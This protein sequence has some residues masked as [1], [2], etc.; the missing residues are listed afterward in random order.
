MILPFNTFTIHSL[1][2]FMVTIPLAVMFYI[3][4]LK[5]GRRKLD[6]LSANFIFC[7]AAMCLYYF[8]VD[9]LIPAG[10]SALGWADGPTADALRSATLQLYRFGWA[11]AI[12]ILPVQLHFVLYYCRRNN[13]LRRYI[14]VGYIVALVLVPTIWFTSLWATIAS[15]P[16]AETSSWAVTIPWLPATG[17]APYVYF[18]VTI[19]IQIYGL[20]LLWRTRRQTVTEF[21]DSLGGR[22]IVFAAFVVQVG[23]GLLDVVNGAVGATVPAMTPVGSGIMGTLLAI[24]VTR[25]R[26]ESDRH[27]FQLEREKAG[28]LECVPQ[29]LLYLSNELDIQWTNDDAAAFTGR[30]SQQLVGVNAKDIWPA[31]SNELAPV[32]EAL[33]TGAPAIREISRPDGPTWVMHASPVAG[34]K[35]ESLG[36]IVLAMDITDIRQAQKAL[37]EANIKILTA[38]EEERRHVAQDLHDSIAQGLTA[39]QMTLHAKAEDIGIETPHGEQ[40]DKASLRAGQIGTEV[41]QISH[42]LYPPALDLLGL[43]TALEEIFDPYRATGIVC[44]IECPD[45]LRSARFSQPIEVALYRTVQESISNGVRHG[46]AK[47]ITIQM[48]QTEDSI[49]V[50]VND[51]GCGFDVSKNSKGLGMTSM[52]GRIDG[53]G[54]SLEIASRPGR[55]SVTASVPIAAAYADAEAVEATT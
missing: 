36:A 8:L 52:N 55:T 16:V 50:T 13:F 20:S 9:N 37:R 30:D 4:Y 27:K 38:R 28:L 54:G 40:F 34:A 46:K 42:Q 2:S 24:A 19:T 35:G 32:L 12:I 43:A 44:N 29:P 48:A 47:E 45:E 1:I 26:I 25:S 17:P 23:V 7:V 22:G 51:N 53:I 18:L 11:I 5:A 31:G 14:W 3:V 15:Q 49:R 39:L 6:L 41:R 33:E 21:A 10:R